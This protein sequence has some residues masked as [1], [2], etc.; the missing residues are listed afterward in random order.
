MGN[1][2]VA[3]RIIKLIAKL[4]FISLGIM[5][6]CV[7]IC[8]VLGKASSNYY[9]TA[10]TWLGAI[11][12]AIGIFSTVGTHQSIGDLGYQYGRSLNKNSYM[13]RMQEDYKLIDNGYLFCVKACIISGILFLFSVFILKI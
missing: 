2:S 4:F 6:G 10:F 11:I 13:D 12:L 1:Q 8:V 9:S 7:L 3:K 5:A